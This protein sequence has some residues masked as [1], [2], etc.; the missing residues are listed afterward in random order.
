MIIYAFPLAW[1][2]N[3]VVVEKVNTSVRKTCILVSTPKFTSHIFL[4]K[5]LNSL[6]F[7]LPICEKFVK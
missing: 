7:N 4:D 3:C 6:H 1:A 2:M 5:L